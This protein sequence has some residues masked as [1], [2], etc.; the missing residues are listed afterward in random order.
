MVFQRFNLFPHL[1]ALGNIIEAPIQVRRIAKADAIATARA[2]LARVGIG[3]QGRQLSSAALRRSAATRR[4]RPR[5]G[6]ATGS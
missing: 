1:T 3:R 5:A 6:D 4:H 2:L